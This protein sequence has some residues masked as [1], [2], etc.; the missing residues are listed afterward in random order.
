M[1]L[2]YGIKVGNLTVIKYLEQR[3][4]RDY[5][6]CGCRCGWYTEVQGR[7]LRSSITRSCGHCRPDIRFNPEHESWLAMKAR[8]YIKDRK[9]YHRYGGRGI[10]V[11]T[12]WFDFFNFLEDMGFRPSLKHTLDR[13][14]TNGNYE[15]DNCKWSTIIEQNNNRNPRNTFI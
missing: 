1:I 11:C 8:C 14:D 5:W 2:S 10:I 13:I 6:L 4:G 9:D 12:Q 7:F 15:P 3:K